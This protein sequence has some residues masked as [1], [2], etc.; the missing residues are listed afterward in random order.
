MSISCLSV[1]DR[2]TTNVSRELR[3]GLEEKPRAA[4]DL[5]VWKAG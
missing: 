5:S 1:S 4:R 3:R 2:P